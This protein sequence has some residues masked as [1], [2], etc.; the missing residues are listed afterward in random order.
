MRAALG[1][2]SVL[3]SWCL[4]HTVFAA[5]YARLYY[6]GSYGGID[7]PGDKHP[8]YA[9][10]GYFAFTVG[11]TYQ[12]SDTNVTDRKMRR[13]TLRHALLS[14]LFGAVIIAT[15]INLVAGLA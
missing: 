15:T 11:M 1:T 10:F 13:T 3:L 8:D 7:F 14:Y 4:I 5:R 6:T 2:G 12:V 9:D